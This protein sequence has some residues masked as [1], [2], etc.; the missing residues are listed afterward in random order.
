MLV[1]VVVG[2]FGSTKVSGGVGGGPILTD[3]VPPHPN[4]ISTSPHFSSRTSFYLD[5]AVDMRKVASHHPRSRAEVSFH[6]RVRIQIASA[7]HVS[8][9]EM[10]S[11]RVCV[12]IGVEV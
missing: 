10:V 3:P 2:G 6:D 4:P 8:V 9:D 11:E 12:E 5:T 7:A 1:A